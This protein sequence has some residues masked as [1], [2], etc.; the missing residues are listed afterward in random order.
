MK[1]IFVF[2]AAIFLASQY[3][4]ANPLAG[5]IRDTVEVDAVA[6][7]AGGEAANILTMQ[8]AVQ[9]KRML[10]KMVSGDS[11][12]ASKSPFSC[13]DSYGGPEL[14]SHMGQAD[15]AWISKFSAFE[16]D[17]YLSIALF[18]RMPCEKFAHKEPEFAGD[19]RNGS[20]GQ[21]NRILRRALLTQALSNAW[22]DNA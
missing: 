6:K 3:A 20:S 22:G 13:G 21:I 10:E 12:N 9:N 2:F 4:L 17:D 1:R 15:C 11:E 8:K 18:S 14:Q 16:F 5:I 19:M 7:V